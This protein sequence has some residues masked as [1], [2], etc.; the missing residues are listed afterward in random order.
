MTDLE[1]TAPRSEKRG[2][3]KRLFDKVMELSAGKHA[4]WLLAVVSFAE[5][6]F[7]PIPPDPVLAAIVLAN[8]KRAWVAALVCTAASV[9]GGLAG[10]AIGAGLYDVIG[11]PVIAFYHLEDAFHAFQARFEEWGGW[12]ILAKGLTPIPFK[13]VTIASG[14][15]H[16]NLTTFVLASLLTRGLRFFIVAGLFYAFGPQ[17]RAIIDKNFPLVMLIGTILVILGFVAIIYI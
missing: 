3:M 15:V 11:A 8:R 5:A 13:L 4:L 7:F 9:L 17:A 10:Y 16:L 12:I 2:F 6:S 14:V 1:A